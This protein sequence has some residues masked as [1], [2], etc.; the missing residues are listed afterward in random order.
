MF[1]VSILIVIELSACGG[2]FSSAAPTWQE[3]YDLG[4]RYLSEGN[5]EEAIIAFTAAIEI[6]PK[7]A[8]AYVGRGDAYVASGETEENLTAAL[9]DYEA[10]LDLDGTL[11]GAYLKLADVYISQGNYD[12]AI[13]ILELGMQ[14]CP[15][16]EM[17]EALAAIAADD[18]YQAVDGVIYLDE[19][20]IN[21]DILRN[22]R[23]TIGG[24]DFV[25][26]SYDEIVAYYGAQRDEF[27]DGTQYA[28]TETGPLGPD[29][30]V[31]IQQDRNLTGVLIVFSSRYGS[32][33]AV[34]TNQPEF[35][36]IRIGDSLKE[37]ITKLGIADGTL[38]FLKAHEVDYF[39]V[40][41][42]ADH[43]Q[44]LRFDAIDLMQTD[45][46]IFWDS[47]EETYIMITL[48]FDENGTLREFWLQRDNK[49]SKN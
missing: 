42:M 14:K 44:P 11:V 4:V 10:A 21:R 36:G 3:Q 28:D 12:A 33:T 43:N 26:M 48:K 13:E 40:Q 32:G 29:P 27:E 6:D 24:R 5:Y 49:L 37:I 9:M 45:I 47:S 46:Q 25:D 20:Y 15:T 16:E 23:A 7:Q 18:V 41:L 8:P 31:H 39:C 35:L 1:L 2:Y 19:T 22:A 34:E 38:D 17:E 30:H